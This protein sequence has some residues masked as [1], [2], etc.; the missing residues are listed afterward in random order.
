MPKRN[1]MTDVLR[2]RLNREI[3]GGKSFRAI[4]QASGVLRQSLMPFARSE[5]SLRLDMADMLA[6]YYGL[7]LKPRSKRRGK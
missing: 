3:D 1:T 7:E 2:D 4:E 6:D 5:A